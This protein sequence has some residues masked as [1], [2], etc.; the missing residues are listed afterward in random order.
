ML[1]YLIGN[2]I[3]VNVN[4]DPVHNHFSETAIHSCG[5]NKI[6]N[7]ENELTL[8]NNLRDAEDEA[9]KLSKD[10]YEEQLELNLKRSGN[11]PPKAFEYP[12]LVCKIQE[13]QKNIISKNETT[14][15][16]KAKNISIVDSH[17][18]HTYLRI[19]QRT[20][21]DREIKSFSLL[22]YLSTN[23]KKR[24]IS[25]VTSNGV[26]EKNEEKGEEINQ[27]ELH[28]SDVKLDEC[29]DQS[30]SQNKKIKNKK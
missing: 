11:C 8:Y 20:V 12:I 24:N 14:F 26:E 28:P 25:D 5:E 30:Q 16:V 17:L 7:K 6:K 21:K 9:K 15:T 10:Y 18:D 2:C 27:S 4:E 1:G 23:K 19:D 22:N 29:L 13:H 3:Q